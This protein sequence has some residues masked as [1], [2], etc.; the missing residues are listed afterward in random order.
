VEFICDFISELKTKKQVLSQ[1]KRDPFNI[2]ALLDFLAGPMGL[3]PTPSGV[4][5]YLMHANLL[6][7]LISTK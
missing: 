5:D 6:I 7:L 2:Q 1:I 3:K 4:T